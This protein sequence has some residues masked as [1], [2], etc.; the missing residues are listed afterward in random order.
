[1][2][3]LRDVLPDGA[4]ISLPPN[5]ASTAQSLAII[6]GLE[7]QAAN[8]QVGHHDEAGMG[9]PRSVDGA[10]ACNSQAVADGGW[11][12]HIFFR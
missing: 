3:R 10:E 5:T 1:M 4:I 7:L 11:G 12:Q 2:Q 9:G 6:F 8:D